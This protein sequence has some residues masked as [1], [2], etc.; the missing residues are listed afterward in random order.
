[1]RIAGVKSGPVGRGDVIEL[2]PEKKFVEAVKMEAC[3]LPGKDDKYAGLLVF[4][5]DVI[6]QNLHYTAK[7]SPLKDKWQNNSYEGEGTGLFYRR[8][9]AT[10]RA[11]SPVAAHV[12]IKFEDV[13]DRSGMPDLKV[14]SLVLETFAR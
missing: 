11:L 3:E 9:L 13:L 14:V 6:I 5:R 8:D 1:M 10:D 7:G 12:K 2:T 4:A